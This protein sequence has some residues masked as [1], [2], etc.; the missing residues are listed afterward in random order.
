MGVDGGKMADALTN[1]LL[2]K[3]VTQGDIFDYTPGSGGVVNFIMPY[4]W[5]GQSTFALPS[6]LPAYYTTGVYSYPRDVI[7]RSTILHEPQWANAVAIAAAKAAAKSFDINPSKGH[8]SVETSRKIKSAHEMMVQWGGSGYVPSQKRGVLDYSCTN[9]G[10]FWEI[11]RSSS[12]AGSKIL[13]LVH[14][15][16]LRCRRTGDPDIPVIYYDLHGRIHELKYYQVF[17][18]VDMP[19]PS[20]P[21]ENIGHCAAERAYSTIYEMAGI[22]TTTNEKITGTGA[23]QLAILQGM[24]DK[25]IKDILVT[26]RNEAQAKGLVYYLGT[27]I[28][29]LASDAPVDIKTLQLRGLP[30]NFEAKIERDNAN[31]IYANALGLVLT[32]LQ[33]LSG[34]GLGTGAQTIVI[35]E[36]ASGRTQASRDKELTHNLNEWVMPDAVTFAFSERDTRDE[37][38][39]ALVSKTREETRNSMILNGTILPIEARQMAADADDLPE[40]FITQDMTPAMSVADEDR[41]DEAVPAVEQAAP[42]APP[43]EMSPRDQKILDRQRPEPI[44]SLPVPPSDVPIKKQPKTAMKEASE[45][46]ALLREA[47]AESRAARGVKP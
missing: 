4:F 39:K 32:D 15:D 3:S 13:G 22:R 28:A 9:N 44:G 16:S 26:A 6:E 19:D 47:I 2:K 38:A 18:L 33:P 34:Q 25:N 17:S 37:Q 29:A 27:I 46:A 1:D 14:L 5:G 23:H 45:I 43:E 36:K 8:Q 7:L 41:S 24:T 31:L 40:E 10:E 20:Y 35:E 21:R 12:A 11:T 42:T 30:E